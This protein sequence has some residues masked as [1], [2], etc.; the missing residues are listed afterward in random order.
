MENGQQ[1]TLDERF[2]RNTFGDAFADE[3]MRSKR[4]FVDVPVGDYKVSQLHDYPRLQEN[5]GP[6]LKYVQ[7]E[8]LDLCVSKSF[9]SALFALGFED[10]AHKINEFGEDILGGAVVNALVCVVE[11][12]KTILPSW[13]VV[14]RI[15]R[16]FDCLHSL[17]KC[18]MLVAVLT[19]SDGSCSHAVTMHGGYVFDANEKFALKLSQ[20]SLDYCCSSATTKAT[21]NRLRRGY[22][23]RYE[24]KRQ[25]KRMHLDFMYPPLEEE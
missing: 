18:D 9:A 3:L 2:V 8:G 14:K 1:T 23:I 17:E 21:F 13:M 20:E 22:F 11:F 15:P 7:E 12:S 19:A 24:G 25:Q 4:G 16:H 5:L 6:A 10:E